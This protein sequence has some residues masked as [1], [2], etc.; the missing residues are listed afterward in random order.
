MKR[1]HNKRKSKYFYNK[2]FTKSDKHKVDVLFAKDKQKNGKTK[3]VKMFRM[4][5]VSIIRHCKIRSD[6]NVFDT[7]NEL[8]FEQRDLRKWKRNGTLAIKK[9]Q[10][11]KMQNSKCPICGKLMF[12][13][14]QTEI[15]RK[16]FLTKGGNV[17]IENLQLVHTECHKQCHLS[18]E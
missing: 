1:R 9:K 10:L 5:E 12:L 3:I 13:N 4:G 6:A 7:A 15:H 14:D 11:R 17:K 16:V 2:Y 18:D 8:Y